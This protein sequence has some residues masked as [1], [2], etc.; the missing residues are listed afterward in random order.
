MD[1]PQHIGRYEIVEELGRGAMGIVYRAKDPAMERIVA[2]KTIISVV[3]SGPQGAEFRVRFYRE[4]RTAGALAHPGI[5][6]VFDVGEHEGMPFLVMEFVAGR[7]L[8]DQLKKGDRLTP[9]RVCEL[10]SQIARALGYAH[11]RGVVHRDIKPANILLTSSEAYGVERPKI[12]DFGV[13]KLA[14]GQTTLTGQMLGTPAYMPPEQFTGSGIDGRSDIFSLG[15]V[16]YSMTTGE[17]PFPGESVT[18][19]SYKVVHTD[20]VPPRRLNPALPAKLESAIMKCLAKSPEDRYQTADEL[21]RDLDEL[22]AGAKATAATASVP[23]PSDP[24]A[25][26]I[27][28][29]PQKTPPE[30]ASPTKK[31]PP[32]ARK[33]SKS[34][35]PLVVALIAVA[36]VAVGWYAF[37]DWQRSNAPEESAATSTEAPAAPSGDTVAPDISKQSSGSSALPNASASRAAVPASSATSAPATAMTPA[38]NANAAKAPGNKADSAPESAANAPPKPADVA[39]ILASVDFDPKTLDRKSNARLDIDAQRMPA[40]LEFTLEMN[41]KI[42]L[43]KTGAEPLSKDDAYYVPPG[44]HEFRVRAKSGDVEKLSNTVSTEFRANKRNSLKIEMRVQGMSS[45][46]GVPQGLYPNSQI[47]LTLK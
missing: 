17:Q 39:S 35:N 8:A 47:V 4:A 15:V 23:E 43:H 45:D 16:L 40:A 19:V 31:A 12:T 18:A 5:V 28:T 34:K 14:E 26:L 10:G 37:R 24:D 38:T 13:A 36:L 46:A 42:Y 3:L 30:A 6:A 27:H 1:A 9:S 21:A 41:G 25:T 7:T 2:L 22:K 11:Q 20:P 32:S 44:I 29:A 33:D